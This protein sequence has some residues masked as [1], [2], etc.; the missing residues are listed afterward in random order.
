MAN[1]KETGELSIT[2][3]LEFT[4]SP[5]IPIKKVSNTESSSRSRRYHNFYTQSVQS[6]ETLAQSGKSVV[7]L[8]KTRRKNI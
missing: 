5:L 2:G 3:S 4:D 6:R 8:Y 1:N 7:Q